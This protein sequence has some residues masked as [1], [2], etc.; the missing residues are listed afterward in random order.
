M[1]SAA[2]QS[3]SVAGAALRDLVPE[4]VRE[5]HRALRMARGRG[6]ERPDALAGGAVRLSKAVDDVRGDVGVGEAA[7]PHRHRLP[8]ERALLRAEQLLH[9][10]LLRAG[11][12]VR[13]DLALVLDVAAQDR[14]RGLHL[15]EILELVERDQRAVAAVLL[16]AQR[17]VEQRV[18][19]GQRVGARLELELHADP[20]RREREAEAGSLQELLDSRADAAAKLRRVCALEPDGDVRKGQDA[21]E[22]DEDR[23]HP[24]AA[25]RL[26]EHA[27]Q[28]ARLPVLPWRVQ[29][30]VVPADGRAQQ[31]G[32]LRVPVDQVLGRDRPR[33]DERI[34]VGDHRAPR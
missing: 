4:P 20:E 16:E 28:Q 12:D 6:D 1:S 19:R 7:E 33:V 18:Q 13:G 25:F 15:A 24:L 31:L 21:E 8:V 27:P 30:D 2:S 17:Q 9:Q 29:P 11:E 22:V 14:V 5:E 32:R 23:D 10:T 34:G 3:G 26:L